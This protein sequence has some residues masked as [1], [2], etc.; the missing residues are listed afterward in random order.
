MTQVGDDTHLALSS[1]E[2][3]V[4]RDTEIS[5]FDKGDFCCPAFHRK[6]R[7]GSG[8]TSAP[9]KPTPCSAAHPTNGSR[10]RATRTSTRAVSATTPISST[11]ATSRSPSGCARASIRWKPSSPYTLP[12]NVENLELLSSSG[13]DG[14]RKRPCQ[15][16]HRLHRRRRAER[17]GRQRLSDRR[18]RRRR[19]VFEIGNGADTVA[20]FSGSESEEGDTLRFMGYG[21]DAYLTN[22]G[23]RL[24]DSLC[25]RSGDFPPGRD[26]VAFAETTTSSPDSRALLPRFDERSARRGERAIRRGSLK[27]CAKA[28]SPCPSLP[29][30]KSTTFVKN[31]STFEPRANAAKITLQRNILSSTEKPRYKLL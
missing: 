31:A 28:M 16:H 25:G 12:G 27:L 6:A 7:R 21:T 3:L 15:P 26:H 29:V 24:D 5:A 18:R 19:F 11:I 30:N 20:D 4:F 13:I 8:P 23:G 1:F 17:Q 10:A 14:Q 22:V 9:P 2:T